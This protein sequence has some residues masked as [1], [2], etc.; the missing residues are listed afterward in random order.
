MLGKTSRV[1]SAVAWVLRGF[2][3]SCVAEYQILFVAAARLNYELASAVRRVLK[4]LVGVMRAVR[5]WGMYCKGLGDASHCGCW[6]SST[7]ALVS[8]SAEIWSSAGSA[9]LWLLCLPCQ[10]IPTIAAF[11]RAS[12][13]LLGVSSQAWK[14]LK[15]KKTQNNC[16]GIGRPSLKH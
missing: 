12:S 11:S 3:V 9:E 14:A 4:C 7:D 2:C 13:V 15:K 6:N 8:C 10:Q 5:A 1:H 16:L